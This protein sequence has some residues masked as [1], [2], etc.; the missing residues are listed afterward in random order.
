MT[1]NYHGSRGSRGWKSNI[2]MSPGLCSL[3]R[4]LRMPL[5]LPGGHWQSLVCHHSNPC[6]YLQMAFFLS[7]YIYV[8]SLFSFYYKDTTHWIK[9]LP[10]S[11]MTLAWLHL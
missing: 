7:E 10:Y 1:E 5:S 4:H 2:K 9:G 6:L 8:K 11:S 3:Q